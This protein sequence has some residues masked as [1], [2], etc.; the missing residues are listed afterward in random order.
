MKLRYLLGSLAIA[1]LPCMAQAQD[2]EEK[3]NPWFIQ[4]GL[5]ASYSVDGGAGFGKMLAPAG[6]IGFGKHFNPYIGARI[7]AGGWKGRYRVPNSVTTGFYDYH[8]TADALWNI[9]KT[10]NHEYSQP[11]SLRFIAGVGFDRA[12][13]RPSSSL[14]V[15]L[16]LSMDVRLC[17]AIDFNLEYQANGVSDRWNSLDDHSFDCFMNLLVGA[18]YKFGTGYRCKTCVPEQKVEVINNRTNAMREIVEVEKIVR[19]TVEIVKEVPVAA[20]ESITRTVFYAIN[21]V[22]VPAAQEVNVAAIANYL[23]SNPGSKAT[24]VG[25]ADKGTGTETINLQLAK[26]RAENVATLLV[27]LGATRSQLEVSSMHNE[28]KEQPFSQNDLNRVVIMTGYPK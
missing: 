3:E 1:L 18:T 6:Q 17:K 20:T 8:F 24:V 27:N 7:T 15:R 9:F 13:A 25:Y 28:Y 23:K 10:F 22:E 4:G 21:Q 2:V 5:G 12:Y 16:G 14:L 11:V 19:D 26:E